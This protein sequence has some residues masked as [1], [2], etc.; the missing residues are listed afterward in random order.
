[1]PK[2]SLPPISEDLLIRF[3]SYCD[4]YLHLKLATIKLYLS[5]IRFSYIRG[6]FGNPLAVADRL[7]YILKGIRKLQ[8]ENNN[9][10]LPI[11]FNILCN[12]CRRLQR[13]LY[14]PFEDT[15]L[16][17]MCQT[18]FFGFLRCGEFT[19]KHNNVHGTDYIRIQDIK[20]EQEDKYFTLLLRASKTDPFRKGVLVHIYTN[21]VLCPVKA[22]RRYMQLRLQQGV[23]SES[24]L[25]YYNQSSITRVKFIEYMRQV[26]E[27]VGLDTKN[28]NGHSFRI[29]AATSA[30]AAGVEDHLIQTLGRWSSNCYTRYIRTSTQVISTAQK[31]MCKK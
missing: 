5:G 30:A 18:A 15:M 14:S 19:V 3:V 4:K 31:Q 16:I 12:M 8:G 9:K 23:N 2:G 6:G 26:L 27:V 10:R 1:M 13:G 24:A 20:F 25:F 29:G 28:Y 17:C 22:M 11:T 7:Q 21:D